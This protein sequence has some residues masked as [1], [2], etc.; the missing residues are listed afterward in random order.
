MGSNTPTVATNE[1]PFPGTISVLQMLG[2]GIW[3]SGQEHVL[4][5]GIYAF[6]LG[7]GA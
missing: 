2:A 3:A 5:A 6:R 1:H 4:E 7:F